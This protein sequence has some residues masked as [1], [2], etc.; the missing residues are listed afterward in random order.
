M[1][2]GV[3]AP[4]GAIVAA[5]R[6]E[7]LAALRDSMRRLERGA[8]AAAAGV[9]P[10]GCPALDAAL[11][12]GLALG[13]L[14]ELGGDAAGEAAAAGFAALLLGRLAAARGRPVLW[15]GAV[16]T[17]HPPGLAGLGLPPDRVV[18]LRAGRPADRLWAMEEGLRS[19]AL[20]GVLGEL[21]EL[22][23]TDSRRL[24]LAAEAGGGLGLVLRQ[25]GRRRAGRS[26]DAERP[27]AALTR[28]RVAPAPSGPPPLPAGTTAPRWDAAGDVAGDLTGDM[29]GPAR[30]LGAPRWRLALTRCRGGRP[31][32][33]LVEWDDATDRFAVVAALR[34]GADPAGLG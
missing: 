34:D 8:A 15:C 12:G 24:Q 29:D 27:S 16:E 33:W 32:G 23:L 18:L 20:A 28:W 26:A 3:L 2:G 14:H 9:L 17:L 13:G 11:G 4:G 6:S 10:L 7:R 22:G 30:L 19:P 21:P 5:E 1:D 31:G 25:G